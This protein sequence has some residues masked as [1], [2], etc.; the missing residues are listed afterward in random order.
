MIVFPNAKI[1]IGLRILRKRPDG[2]HD[3]E[4]L[5]CPIGWSDVLELTETNV[6]TDTYFFRG[7]PIG[8][9]LEKNL[10][11]RAVQLLRE[12]YLF[13][14]LRIELIK[15]IPSQAGLGGGSSDATFVMQAINQM[16]GL[17]ISSS[18]L[19]AWVAC[20]G[21]DCAFFVENRLAIGEG[22]GT[23]L[24][25]IE[26]ALPWAGFTLVVVAPHIA[27]STQEAYSRVVPCNN[28]SSSL[29]EELTLD[30]EDWKERITNDF[31]A[32]LFPR[33]PELLSIKNTLYRLGASYASLSGSGSAL[34]GIFREV[35]ENLFEE[36]PSHYTLWQGML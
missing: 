16:F 34:Y 11:Y 33:Y 36:F 7:I 19:Q 28:Y 30:S 27:I 9:P 35:P 12:R 25:P 23:H 10:I 31:E 26:Q 4:T 17:G 5:F 29:A 3:I 21:A 32:S 2:Y 18:D 20:L 22:I 1:N 15:N 24:T 13:P 8:C 14:F 6:P